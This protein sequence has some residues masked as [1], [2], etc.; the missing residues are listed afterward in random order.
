M[1]LFVRKST[2]PSD[3]YGAIVYYVDGNGFVR[4]STGP[5]DKYGAIVYYVDNNG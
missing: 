5:S 4:K 2:A 1:G 3:K